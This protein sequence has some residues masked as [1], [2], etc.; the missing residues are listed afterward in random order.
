MNN[1]VLFYGVKNE[2]CII[3]YFPLVR[4]G[5]TFF[6]VGQLKQIVAE[7]IGKE[8]GGCREAFQL[9][10]DQNGLNEISFDRKDIML[11][12][13][14]PLSFFYIKYYFLQTL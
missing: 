11:L 6:P 9:K 5:H 3:S 1:K 4:S 8:G 14:F 10:L 12:L 7:K 13:Q 2:H